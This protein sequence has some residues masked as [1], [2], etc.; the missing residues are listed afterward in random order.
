LASSYGFHLEPSS[1]FVN[2]SFNEITAPPSSIGIS[3]SLTID[4]RR[5]Q[6]DVTDDE[7][8]AY[9]VKFKDHIDAF[10]D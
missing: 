7:M 6:F 2:K 9:I 5:K 10:K 8:E 4:R 3:Q 1:E